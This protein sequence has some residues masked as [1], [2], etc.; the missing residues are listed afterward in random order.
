LGHEWFVFGGFRFDGSVIDFLDIYDLSK[1]KWTARLKTPDDIPQSHLGMTSDGKRYIYLVAGQ[2]GPHCRPPTANCFVFD[3]VNRSWEKI[4]PLPKARYA[5]TVQLWQGRLHTVGGSLEDRGTPAVD[6]WSIAVQDGKALEKEWRREPSIPR[7]GPHRASAVIDHKLYVF[8]GQEGDYIAIPG[9]PECRCT[10]DLT[11]EVVYADTYMLEAGA[12]EWKRMADM[13]VPASHT[14]FTVVPFGDRIILMGGQCYKHPTTKVIR[15]T[16][17]IQLYD[18]KADSWKI[19]G[20]LPY[21]VKSMVTTY[22]NGALFVTTGQ[23]D[24]SSRDAAALDRFERG[25]WKVKFSL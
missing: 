22:Y 16:D 15:L 14:E 18:A 12:K 8:G 2:L 11:S 7:G 21:R 20:R 5:P 6:H 13:V 24:K 3:T 9:D 17:S 1:E 10:G 25:L 19:A 23:R 4:V